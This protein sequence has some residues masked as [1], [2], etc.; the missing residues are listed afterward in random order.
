MEV[1][2]WSPVVAG[3]HCFA[4]RCGD[5]L[6]YYSLEVYGGEC[7]N[8]RMG[9]SFVLSHEGGSAGVEH[10]VGTQIGD[11]M[12]R[13]IDWREMDQMTCIETLA[14]VVEAAVSILALGLSVV[15][16]R[17]TQEQ[18]KLSNKQSLF[19]R[20]L[21]IYMMASELVHYFET[22]RTLRQRVSVPV[23]S[24]AA[25]FVL[26]APEDIFS[27][28]SECISFPE[29]LD[30]LQTLYSGSESLGTT[31][32]EA[33]FVFSEEVGTRISLFVEDYISLLIAMHRYEQRAMS[34][35][36]SIANADISASAS[37]EQA[38]LIDEDAVETIYR[39]L[40]ASYDSMIDESTL[41]KATEEIKLC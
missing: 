20:R 6:V 24:Y 25:D 22:Y 28:V 29:A 39:R 18:I 23:K 13:Q 34:I 16:I 3:L 31:A 12:M 10:W 41:D 38:S 33:K 4:G 36:N 7:A 8:T 27:D 21:A 9:E 30:S 2:E 11:V 37:K 17:Q 35:S 40:N 19:D 15:S 26:L 5:E 32:Q 14:V 1:S